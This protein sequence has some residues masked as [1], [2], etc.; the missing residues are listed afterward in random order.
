VASRTG[1]HVD[2]VV[3]ADAELETGNGLL[4]EPGSAEALLGAVG[5]AETA[6]SSPH[7]GLLRRRV[8]RRDSGW[9]RPARRYAQLYR[10]SPA[11][12]PTA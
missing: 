4:F 5:R 12:S 3:D 9:E 10:S 6:W 8:M 11:A 2:A 7:F 1:G